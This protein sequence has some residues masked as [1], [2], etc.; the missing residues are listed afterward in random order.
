MIHKVSGAVPA[1]RPIN[2]PPL[3][4][5]D[6]RRHIMTFRILTPDVHGLLDY[7]AG[8]GL[9]VLPLLLELDAASPL[10]F[11]LSIVAGAGLVAYSLFTDYAFGAVPVLSFR[12][13]LALDLAAAAA[14]A[15]AP[16]VFGWTGVVF[17]YYL[18]MSAGVLVVV[19]LS[20][21]ETKATHAPVDG[22]DEAAEHKT[23]T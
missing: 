4:A 14:F 3:A 12:M 17:A 20:R 19:A 5:L 21:T 6:T 16:F 9:V 15:A 13:H 1:Y 11:W 7:A 8:A 10:A 2:D 22:A 18:V 23:A